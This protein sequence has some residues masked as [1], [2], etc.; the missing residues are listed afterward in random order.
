MRVATAHSFHL[1]GGVE[2]P[3]PIRT[4][5]PQTYQST[6]TSQQLSHFYI[7]ETNRPTGAGCAA[8]LH[9]SFPS[10]FVDLF[11]CL[12]GLEEK[13]GEWEGLYWFTRDSVKRAGWEELVQIC[14]LI[15]CRVCL[16]KFAHYNSNLPTKHTLMISS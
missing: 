3:I 11:I 1:D 14:V 7:G 6:S 16:Y 13:G 8:H 2:K 12:P 15:T 10:A 5:L 4:Q 9:Q